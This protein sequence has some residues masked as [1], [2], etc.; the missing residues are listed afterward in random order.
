[1]AKPG[2]IQTQ[3]FYH[4]SPFTKILI[5]EDLQQP[6]GGICPVASILFSLRRALG[7]LVWMW[8]GMALHSHLQPTWSGPQK[9]RTW[10]TPKLIFVLHPKATLIGSGMDWDPTHSSLAGKVTLNQAA[11]EVWP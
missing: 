10:T 7:S 6:L 9:Q 5:A 2:R 1:M 11:H 8:E 4:S 3:G